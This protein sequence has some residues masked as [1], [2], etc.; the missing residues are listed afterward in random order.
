MVKGG[1]HGRAGR[2]RAWMVAW[3][4]KAMDD[5][6]MN[7]GGDGG[8]VGGR[9]EQMVGWTDGGSILSLKV[10]V[11]LRKLKGCSR[12]VNAESNFEVRVEKGDSK[13]SNNL[14]ERTH[15][16]RRRVRVQRVSVRTT[17]VHPLAAKLQ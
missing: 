12:S 3:N 4:E 15:H 5:G 10:L 7:G 17:C 6:Q 9:A 16:E 2:G 14:K 1:M 11:L 8:T 13:K